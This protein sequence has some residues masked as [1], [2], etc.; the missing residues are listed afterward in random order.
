MIYVTLFVYKF[1]W[2][3]FEILQSTFR[4][5]VLKLY[6][7]FDDEAIIK[8][9]LNGRLQYDKKIEHVAIVV[10]NLMDKKEEDKNTAESKV[11]KD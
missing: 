8:G 4:Y 9:C 2:I 6:F 1:A 5:L 10:N 11:S 7:A 3:N